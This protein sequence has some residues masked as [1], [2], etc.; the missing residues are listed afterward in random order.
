MLLHRQ[1]EFSVID[2]PSILGLRPVGVELLPQ[3]LRETGLL[4]QLKADYVGMVAP[5]SA[6]NY[7]R[8]DATKLLNPQ[9]MQDYTLK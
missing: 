5:T 9:A 4:E 1:R 2:A 8:D 6:Y 7:K 3:A